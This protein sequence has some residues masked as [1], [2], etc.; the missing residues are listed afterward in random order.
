M[1]YHSKFHRHQW[2]I[3]RQPLSEN[4]FIIFSLFLGWSVDRV[5]RGSPWTP[6]A[7]EGWCW[8]GI[9][10]FWVNPGFHM[11]LTYLGHSCRHGLGHQYRICENLSQFHIYWCNG[12]K[13]C[14]CDLHFMPIWVH[15]RSRGVNRVM[16]IRQSVPFFHH[17]CRSTN[18][19]VQI[20]NYNHIRKQKY[21]SS[22]VNW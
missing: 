16:Q 4:L 2:S 14:K 22:K 20:R 12:W 6:I 18:I 19:F 5:H 3:F 17:I 7:L 9:S 10:V 8:Q 1:E 21:K 15:Q 11:P 13:L